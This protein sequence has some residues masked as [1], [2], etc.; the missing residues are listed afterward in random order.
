MTISEEI[1][2]IKAVGL[3]EMKPCQFRLCILHRELYKE[4]FNGVKAYYALMML[5]A[6]DIKP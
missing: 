3:K 2:I 4:V 1:E 5:Y 6:C